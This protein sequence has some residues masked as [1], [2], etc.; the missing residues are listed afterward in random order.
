[1]QKKYNEDIK[2]GPALFGGSFDPIHC[3]H[4]AIAESVLSLEMIDEVIFI[5][6]S[7]SPLKS[8]NSIASN[9]QRR[10]M[11]L[12]AIEGIEGFSLDDRELK[13]G[14]VSYTIHTIEA[15]R[16]KSDSDLYFIIGAD[17]LHQLHNWYK[18]DT[19]VH[20]LK[21]LV[22]PRKGYALDE[23]P[24]LSSK[25]IDYE[26]LNLPYWDMSSTK[27]RKL[28]EQS[29]SIEKFVPSNVEAFIKKHQIY[30]SS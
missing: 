29:E 5:P 19:L 3:G 27:I 26:V 18:V 12:E 16:K 21:F 11:V 15:Y 9:A 23:A 2:R 17:Q 8:H 6:N 20:E 25:V 7:L 14:G 1:M 13:N 10:D 24:I 4:V 30:Q 22:Y 28:C